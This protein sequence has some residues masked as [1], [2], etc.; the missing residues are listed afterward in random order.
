MCS[1]IKLTNGETILAKIISSDDEHLCVN[2]PIQLKVGTHVSSYMVTSTMWVPLR[3]PTTLV[4]LKQ[5][6]VVATANVEEDMSV[7]YRRAVATIKQDEDELQKIVSELRKEVEE[8]ME[9]QLLLG[10]ETPQQSIM[11]IQ[12]EE[13]VKNKLFLIRA[14]TANTVH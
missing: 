9:E 11:P 10:D 14:R 1:I 6:H 12:S 8:R 13:D 5:N 4:A 2:D 7:F 3:S